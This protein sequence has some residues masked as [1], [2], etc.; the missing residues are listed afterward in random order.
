MSRLRRRWDPRGATMV[1]YVLLVALL[2]VALI[3]S[4]AIPILET[5]LATAF[6]NMTKDLETP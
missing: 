1:E 3:V 5:S 2:G 4:G 6:G